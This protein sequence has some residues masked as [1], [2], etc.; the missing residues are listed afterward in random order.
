MRRALFKVMVL[1]ILRDRGAL[2]MSF[3]LPGLVFVIYAVIF[4]GAAGGDLNVK[5]AVADERGTVQSQ[6]LLDALA[7]VDGITLIRED[8]MSDAAVHGFVR[9]GSA[10]V[11]LVVRDNETAFNDI[12]GAGDAP[13]LVVTDPAREIAVSVLRG[14]LQ[15]VYFATF[16]DAVL[17]S[18]ARV[19]GER[20]IQFSP[21]QSSALERGFEAMSRRGEDAGPVDL[22]LDGFFERADIV[23][24]PEVPTSITYYAGAVAIMFLLF[25]AVNGAMTV[26]EERESGIFARLAA[27]PGGSGAILDGKFAFLVLQGLAQVT[28]IYLVAWL[29]FGVD[30]PG[31]LLMWL[32]TSIAA[33]VAA[34]GIALLF[35]TLCGTR[36][37]AQ[38]LGNIAILVVSALGGSMVPR[39]LM[40]PF[41]QDIG[42]ITPNTWVL[43]AY[44]STFW[45]GEGLQ[46]IALPV[47]A[48]AMAGGVGLVAAHFTIRRAA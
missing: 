38:V 40:P 24:D 4:S 8:G 5:L 27:G 45:R 28:V 47:L 3:L 10:D 26:I 43:E 48:L 12:S 6:R 30:L 29:G 2:A 25:S 39:F 33:A 37:Q 9:S 18:T 13:L 15:K 22:G 11:G 1:S 17:K 7:G 35:V 36:Q 14:A 19:L 31:H 44:A 34:A 41:V 23:G 32:V 46:E 42:W 16:P 21:D 20:F